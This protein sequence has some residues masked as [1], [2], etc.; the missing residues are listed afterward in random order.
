MS[1]APPSSMRS[2]IRLRKL[3]LVAALELSFMFIRGLR[4]P[5]LGLS[6]WDPAVAINQLPD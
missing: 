1:I 2:S 3:A 6:V 5:M 4:P